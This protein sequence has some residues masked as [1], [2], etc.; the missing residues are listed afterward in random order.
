VLRQ[1]V[2]TLGCE[3]RY[4]AGS[5]SGDGRR[6][7]GGEVEVEELTPQRR[8]LHRRKRRLDGERG[9][10]VAVTV[11]TTTTGGRDGRVGGWNL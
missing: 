1:M 4:G 5:E 9:A 2:T 11:T 6:A 10:Q 8:R 3:P 7:G